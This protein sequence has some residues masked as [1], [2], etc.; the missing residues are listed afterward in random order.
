M[1]TK[2]DLHRP[3]DQLPD[4][5]VSKAQNFLEILRDQK[6]PV[7]KALLRAPEDD[8]PERLFVKD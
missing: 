2:Q 4:S 5:A 7:L 3:V 8:D 6:D 1:T